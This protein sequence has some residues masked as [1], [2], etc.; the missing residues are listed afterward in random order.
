MSPVLT[1]APV[2][3][4]HYLDRLCN[5]SDP[6]FP[7][8]GRRLVLVSAPPCFAR[9]QHQPRWLRGMVRAGG[10]WT[11]K[12]GWNWPTRLGSMRTSIAAKENCRVCWTARSSR[13]RV[14]ISRQG[15]QNG[16]TD[17]TRS[18]QFPLSAMSRAGRL[19]F[20]PGA[21]YRGRMGSPGG[22]DPGRAAAG[23]WLV[24]PQF[25]QHAGGARP[26]RGPGGGDRGNRGTNRVSV[27]S[28]AGEDPMGKYGDAARAVAHRR[29]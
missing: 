16:L 2:L 18:T 22:T 1:R 27:G 7:W 12:P 25:E 23:R 10:R 26:S 24:P 17:G 15:G 19:R 3:T 13:S 28:L 11:K 21:R 4:L 29:A 20:D 5:G 14:V 6:E 9:R 8:M